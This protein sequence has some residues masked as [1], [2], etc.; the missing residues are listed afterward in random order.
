MVT[1]ALFSLESGGPYFF[2]EREPIAP[3][4]TTAA[5]ASG[6]YW[7]HSGDPDTSLLSIYSCRWSRDSPLSRDLLCPSPGLTGGP[8][9]H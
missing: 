5:P 7:G 2:T 8:S 9:S 4:L 1:K 6:A 3:A